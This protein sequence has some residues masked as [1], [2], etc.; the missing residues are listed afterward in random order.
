LD[1]SVTAGIPT[2]STRVETSVKITLRE[3]LAS[4]QESFATLVKLVDELKTKTKK[5]ERE[6]EEFKKHQQKEYNRLC[7][8]V[9]HLSSPGN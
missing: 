3:Q 2:S 9:M 6:F 4:E 7:D 5:S 1:G 8:Q